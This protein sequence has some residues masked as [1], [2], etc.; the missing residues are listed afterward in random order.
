MA[1]LRPTAFE[2]DPD[3]DELRTFFLPEHQF[4]GDVL[5]TFGTSLKS[6]YVNSFEFMNHAPVVQLWR[7]DANVIQ[8]VSRISLGTGEWFHQASPSH[9]TAEVSNPIINQADAALALLTSRSGWSTVR[10]G[11]KLDEIEHLERCGY[12]G[13]NAT[14]V[15][16]SR[17]LLEPIKAVV[18]PDGIDVRIL[19]PDDVA[20]VHER[21]MAQVDAF[22]AGAPTKRER[23]WITR[24]LPHQLEYRSADSNLS[25]IAVDEGRTVLGFADPFFDCVN[26]IGEFEPVGTRQ[27]ARQQGLSKAVLARGLQEMRDHGMTEAI[28]RTGIENGAAIAA[29]ESV[30]FKIVERLVRFTQQRR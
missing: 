11:S 28:V 2:G 17:S 3:V 9:R 4:D 19:D 27:G 29:Y 8:A 7:D 12:V 18:V 25:V 16:M 1:G 26:G 21:A 30:G 6:A 10:Y 23:A 22:S 15:V 20:A 5:W 24:S 14:E 13:S